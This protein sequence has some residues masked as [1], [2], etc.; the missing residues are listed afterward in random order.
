M[1]AVLRQQEHPAVRFGGWHF[2]LG[3][4]SGIQHRRE[5]PT[6][7]NG[8]CPRLGLGTR[9]GSRLHNGGNGARIQGLSRA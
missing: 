8:L 1:V 5:Y 7:P 6:K 9:K 3:E 2:I 4:D